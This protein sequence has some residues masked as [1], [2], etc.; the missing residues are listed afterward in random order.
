[1]SNPFASPEPAPD[2]SNAGFS[3]VSPQSPPEAVG[4]P[5]A[6]QG[7]FPSSPMAPPA[8]PYPGAQP[9]GYPG[10]PQPQMPYYPPTAPGE[11]P[12]VPAR[13]PSLGQRFG[14]F[15]IDSL[16]RWFVFGVP[17]F[18]LMLL[19]IS[20]D[21]WE[22]FSEAMDDSAEAVTTEA[23]DTAVLVV[24]GLMILALALVWWLDVVF[25]SVLTAIKGGT[26][27]HLV[28]GTR[29]YRRD[30]VTPL[31]FGQSFAR[32]F[33]WRTMISGSVFV[34]GPFLVLFVFLSPVFSQLRRRSWADMIAGTTV[35]QNP[36]AVPTFSAGSIPPSGI[37]QF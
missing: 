34:L 4:A 6:S 31:G 24:L 12:Y 18:A 25:R 32:H 3:P 2:H 8:A 33:V 9:Q 13:I 28:T 36:G 1:M 11:P 26:I 23:Q 22:L 14:G 29:I 5:M 15:V 10:A 19:P 30:E 7:Q 35:V 37:Q 21:T 16:I 27:G 20:E 17:I